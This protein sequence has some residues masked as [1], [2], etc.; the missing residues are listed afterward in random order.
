MIDLNEIETKAV[1]KLDGVIFEV[2]LTKEVW[3]PFQHEF[4]VFQD[5]VS[6]KLKELFSK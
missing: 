5:W 1:E 6:K 2:D 4:R 3:I